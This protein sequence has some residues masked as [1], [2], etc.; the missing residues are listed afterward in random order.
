M[1]IKDC[2]KCVWSTLINE[3]T[4]YCPF[5]GCMKGENTMLDIAHQR[6]ANAIIERAVKDYKAALAAQDRAKISELRN[7]FYGPWFQR[8]TDIDPDVLLKKVAKEMMA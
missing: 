1:K 6:V 8:L 2:L 3:N 4:L 7:F 5:R